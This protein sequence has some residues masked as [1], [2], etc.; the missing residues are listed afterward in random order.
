MADLTQKQLSRS[1]TLNI[2]AGSM[3]SMWFIVCSPQ[4]IFN[5]F[6]TNALGFSSSDLGLLLSITQFT[7]VFQLVSIFIYGALARRKPFVIA[8]HIVQRVYAFVLAGVAIWAATGRSGAVTSKAL[9]VIFAAM[10]VAWVSWN[11]C[12][13]GWWSWVADI[14][15]DAIRGSFFGRRSAIINTVNIVWFFLIT[16]VLDYVPPEGVYWAYAGVFLIAGAVGIV[17]L[18]LH[19]GIPE[20]MRQSRE[21]ISFSDFM[22]PLRDKNYLGFMIAI[23]LSL[24][25]INIFAPFTGPYTTAPGGIGAPNTWLGISNALAQLATIAAAPLMGIMMDRFGRKPVVI[26]GLLS[27]LNWI[28]YIFISGMNYVFILPAM[29]LFSGFLAV[30]FWEGNNQMMLSLTPEKNR[31]AYVSWYLAL[32]GMIASLGPYFGGRLYDLLGDID[33]SPA[34]GIRLGSF[35]IVMAISL[36]LCVVCVLALLRVREKR[37]RTLGYVMS[38]LANPDFYRTVL[39]LNIISTSSEAE[40]TIRALRRVDGANSDI[41]LAEIL[42]RAYDADTEVRFEAVRALG[43][44]GSPQ[45]VDLL[46]DLLREASGIRCAAAVSLGKIADERALEE[47]EK[48]LGSESLDFQEACAQAIGMIGREHPG[49]ADGSVKR[50]SIRYLSNRADTLSASTAETVTRLGDF[51]AAL[52]IYPLYRTSQN[53][54]LRRQ[55]ALALA[56]LLGRP[57][58]F[59]QYVSGDRETQRIRQERLARAAARNARG[60][61]KTCAPSKA[62]DEELGKAMLAMEERLRDGNFAAVLKESL[63]ANR[64]VIHALARGAKGKAGGLAASSGKDSLTALRQWLTDELERASASALQVGGDIVILDALLSLYC[65]A[66]AS[67]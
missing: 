38:R 65:L 18:I 27:V 59:Y 57:G 34:P 21:K 40:R 5:V 53:P 51:D 39:N 4:P 10:T 20:P 14:F 33:L 25:S 47:L 49:Q 26:L 52:D 64:I 2:V 3:G 54:V 50:L 67:P 22:A 16:L 42:D 31:T 12:S 32:T 60:I 1:M 46:L 13:S 8:G 35:Q 30:G 58:E 29:S 17:D 11:I 24:F 43:R 56:N 62:R 41:A 66:C 61:S 48:G 45:T 9:P 23:G 63:A 7:A 28:G 36:A 37:E 19:L 6:L 44:I 15:P 55:M